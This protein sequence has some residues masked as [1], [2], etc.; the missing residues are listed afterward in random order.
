MATYNSVQEYIEQIAL[1]QTEMHDLIVSEGG[2]KPANSLEQYMQSLVDLRKKFVE[3][4]ASFGVEASESE[5]M[6]PA[7]ADKFIFIIK[8]IFKPTNTNFV[9]NYITTSSAD[10]FGGVYNNTK[11]ITMNVLEEIYSPF[12]YGN[13]SLE[14]IHMPNLKKIYNH[15]FGNLLIRAGAFEKC[16][17]LHII[18]LPSIEEISYGT[19]ANSCTNTETNVVFNNLLRIGQTTNTSDTV[20]NIGA[21]QYCYELKS[22]VAPNC[23]FIGYG[24]FTNCNKLEQVDIKNVKTICATAF[25]GCSNLKGHLELPLAVLE[26]TTS[27][28]YTQQQNY[29]NHFGNC[30]KI[31][32]VNLSSTKI[33]PYGAFENCSSMKTILCTPNEIRTKAFYNCQALE[34]FD[35]S[36]LVK[37]SV[38]SETYQGQ[39]FYNC[40]ALTMDIYA[41]KLTHIYGRGHFQNTNITSFEAPVLELIGESSNFNGC[42]NLIYFKA[43]L[44]NSMESTSNFSGCTSLTDVYLG[45]ISKIQNSTFNGCTS[46]TDVYL[47]YDGVVS[48][49]NVNAFSSATATNPVTLHVKPDYADSYATATNWSSLIAAGK[50]IIVG[51]YSD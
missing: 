15:K 7:W 1:L 24:T 5:K 21:F 4:L 20:Y 8:E 34:S 18:D 42:K 38:S 48:L 26:Y 30:S 36:E 22:F 31:E 37:M 28:S 27:S 2:S 47:G 12:A 29:P 33:I 14:E 32:S 51:D 6:S 45:L 16:R 44:L 35:F 17:N 39:S 13:N 40:T 43:P 3:L 19:F 11:T 49:A 25:K 46:L 41:P 9:D 50:I 10:I 23:I